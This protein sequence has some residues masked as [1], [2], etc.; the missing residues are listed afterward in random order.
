MFKFGFRLKRGY[1]WVRSPKKFVK[2]KVRYQ[3]MLLPYK[4]IKRLFK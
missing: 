4:F 3:L 2:N 1:G